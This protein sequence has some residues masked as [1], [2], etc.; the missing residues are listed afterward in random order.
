MVKVVSFMLCVFTII[1]SFKRKKLV[2]YHYNVW[3]YGLHMCPH[4][5]HVLKPSP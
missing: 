5:V 4:K 1:K 3:Y 2:I